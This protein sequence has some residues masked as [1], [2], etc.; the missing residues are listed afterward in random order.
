MFNLRCW[1]KCCKKVSEINFLPLMRHTYSIFNPEI[2]S[3]FLWMHGFFP[4]P[5]TPGVIQYDIIIIIVTFLYINTKYTSIYS[6]AAWTVKT[7]RK[8]QWFTMPIIGD[9]ILTFCLP[10]TINVAVIFQFALC[11]GCRCSFYLTLYTDIN[12][13]IPA[14]YGHTATL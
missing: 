11:G 10:E 14:E 12:A 5:W 7:R 9:N 13:S 4:A 1:K 8:S 6:S 2:P 3:P